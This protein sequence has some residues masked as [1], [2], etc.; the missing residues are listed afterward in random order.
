[1]GHGE[2][3]PLFGPSTEKSPCSSRRANRYS[4]P[5]DILGPEAFGRNPRFVYEDGKYSCTPWSG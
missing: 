4:L 2:L 5:G 3:A 1:M